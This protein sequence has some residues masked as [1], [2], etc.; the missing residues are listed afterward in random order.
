MA[1]D[2]EIVMEH[3]YALIVAIVTFLITIRTLVISPVNLEPKSQAD[4]I[5]T[6]FRLGMVPG[7]HKH[8][9]IFIDDENSSL[10]YLYILS[11]IQAFTHPLIIN[12]SNINVITPVGC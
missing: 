5:H 8:S 7:R 4:P 9:R 6:S 3:L 11:F 2:K 1:D 10:N 12:P